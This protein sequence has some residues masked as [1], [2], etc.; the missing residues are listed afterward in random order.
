M[1]SPH[2]W[3][4]LAMVAVG[5]ILHYCDQLSLLQ[6]GVCA[7]QP[8]HTMD[9][10]LFVVPVAYAGFIFGPRM[11]VLILAV[12]TWLMLP[13]ALL[14]SPYPTRA[15]LE[16]LSTILVSCLILLWFRGQQRERERRLEVLSRLEMARKELASQVDVIRRSE[17][18]LAAIN[19]VGSVVSQSLELP[20]VLQRVLDQVVEEMG[21]SA[22]MIFLKDRSGERLE[23][24][25]HRGVSDEFARATTPLT[26]GV[27]FN[28]RVAQ[29]GE[30]MVVENVAQDPRL[31]LSAVVE[32]G[33]QSQ[34]IVPLRSKGNTIGTLCVA[35]RSS[36]TFSCDDRELLAAIG[37]QVGIAIENA[38]L[39]QEAINSQ[40]KYRD[41]FD[42]ATV[43]IFVQDLDGRITQAN[44]ACVGLTGYS[45]EELTGLSVRKL[46][47][48]HAYSGLAKVQQAL[49]RGEG[50]ASPYDI[51]M[52]R[53]DGSECILSMTTRLVSENGQPRGFQ[54]IAIDVT[55]RRRMRDTLN[56]YVRQVLTAQEEERKRIARELH[57]ETAQSLLL[58]LQ[59]VDAISYGSDVKLPKAA[60]ADLEE[61]RGLLLQT[62]GNVRRLT[63]DLRPQILDDLGLVPAV[64]WLVEEVEK[65]C[66]L[67]GTVQVVGRR[68]QL[69]QET[70]LLLF[71]IAQEALSN[72]RKHSAATE[73]SVVLS[74]GKDR[75]SITIEDNGRGFRMP[76]NVS[77]LASSGKLG[78]LGMSERARLAG[79]SLFIDALPGRG[80]RVVAE[81]AG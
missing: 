67:K 47:P 63:R 4:T 41:L 28:G 44:K 30:P 54:H 29:T 77:E 53:R 74:F 2:L 19:E 13:R 75:V 11:G 50:L 10:V 40:E 78:L 32:E 36:R 23:L 61:L 56:Y 49:L 22:A 71:R 21:V 60:E 17:R 14:I 35:V 26:V 79:G 12:V 15:I 42:N 7:P 25:A 20:S 38:R 24:V 9:R 65:Q 81:L 76:D 46:I 18:R 51:Q 73:A 3:L 64:E 5:G 43:A 16:V 31:C 55:E 57:D 62:L 59:R 8:V 70:Q 39:Y 45:L 37:S 80:T 66:G 1:N 34:L 68:R 48:F 52:V 58:T 33:I 27:G 72:V 6:A 69:P